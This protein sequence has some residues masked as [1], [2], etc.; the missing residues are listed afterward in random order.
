MSHHDVELYDL[1][2]IDDLKEFIAEQRKKIEYHKKEISTLRSHISYYT[3]KLNQKEAD[4]K[5]KNETWA[6]KRKRLAEEARL[7][8][9]VSSRVEADI[10]NKIKKIRKKK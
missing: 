6:D 4:A 1:E 5:R 10:F 2:N 9:E 3:K 8:L 7:R